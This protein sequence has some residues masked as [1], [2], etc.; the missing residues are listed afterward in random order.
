MTTM[1]LRLPMQLDN[2][3]KNLSKEI[4][5]S[6]TYIMI[7]ALEEYLKDYE[8]YLIA[9]NRLHDKND[10]IL[11]LKEFRKKFNV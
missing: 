3:L 7:N 10:E 5:R 9:V 11:S 2:K 6:K 4:D 8:D 1:S